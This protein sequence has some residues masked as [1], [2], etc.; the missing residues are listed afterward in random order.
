MLQTVRYYL[1]LVRCLLNMRKNMPKLSL[2]NI[3]LFKT[4]CSSLILID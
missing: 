3:G 2:K 4:V 1:T